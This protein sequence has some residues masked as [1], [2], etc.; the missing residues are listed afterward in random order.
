MLSKSSQRVQ[1]HLLKSFQAQTS[2]RT[3]AAA[4]PELIDHLKKMGITNKNIVHNPT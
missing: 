1:Q 2:Y 4:T 3:F